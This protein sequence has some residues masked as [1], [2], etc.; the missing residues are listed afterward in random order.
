MPP[1]GKELYCALWRQ[2]FEAGRAGKVLVLEKVF[3]HGTLRCHM[4]T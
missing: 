2:L 3:Y 4:V 1:D